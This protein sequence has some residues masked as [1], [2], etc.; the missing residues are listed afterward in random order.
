M[1]AS[2]IA[3]LLGVYAGVVAG[4]LLGRLGWLARAAT[5]AGWPHADP[6][7]LLSRVVFTVFVPALLFR[8]TARID[9]AGL[10]WGPLAAYFAPAV[11]LLLAVAAVVAWRRRGAAGEPPERPAVAAIT[12]TFSNTAQLGIPVAAALFGESGLALHLAVIALHA[13]ILMTLATVLAELARARAAG[14]GGPRGLGRLLLQTTRHALI[15]PVVLPVLAGLAW[16]ATGWPLPAGVD[17]VLAGLAAAAVP[18]CLLLIGLSLAEGD[19]LG[20]MRRAIGP[21]AFKLLAFPAAVAAV[22]AG[23]AGLAGLPLQVLVM[24]AALPAG[25]NVLLFAQR[26]RVDEADAAAA[27]VGSTVLYAATAPLWLTLLRAFG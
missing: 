23:V 10:P 19:A 27:V 17:R 26:Y 16:S 21:I 7:R 12:A 11:A 22:A 1:N 25:S 14:R 2:V 20:A 9:A 8:T 18:L 24:A 4:W 5:A 13:L 15:H 3:P 6:V